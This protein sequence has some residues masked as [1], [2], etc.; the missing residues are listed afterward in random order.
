MG[1][2]PGLGRF[3]MLWSNQ[4]SVPQ[5]LKPT[6]PRAHAP[7]QKKPPQGETHALQ[8]ETSPHSPQVEKA[9]AEQRAKCSQK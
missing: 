3:H 5:I 6:H 4:A 9:R 1:S 2:T 7:Q 8:P